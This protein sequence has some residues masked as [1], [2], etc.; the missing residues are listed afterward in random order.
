MFVNEGR[1][2]SV[3][4]MRADTVDAELDR[5]ISRRA[6]TDTQTTA[7]ELEP[8]YQESVRRHHEKI[9]QRN[10]WEWVRFFDR[11]AESHARIA[12]DYERRA[13]EL[14]TDERKRA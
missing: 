1:E 2:R 14:C 8:G 4:V 9:R 7:D 6:S 10:R 5:L 13:E 3:G 11:M 12:Q